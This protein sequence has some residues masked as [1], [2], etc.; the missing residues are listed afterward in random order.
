[1]QARQKSPYQKSYGSTTRHIKP[2]VDQGDKTDVEKIKV[3]AYRPSNATFNNNFLD[4]EEKLL[5]KV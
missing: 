3:P 4:N 1:L 5:V 2:P